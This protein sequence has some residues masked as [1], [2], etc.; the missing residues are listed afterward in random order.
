MLAVGEHLLSEFQA[1]YVC[2]ATPFGGGVGGTHEEL[3]GAF[4]SGLMVIGARR[5][6]AVVQED[7]RA[8]YAL[9]VEYRRWF[10]ERWGTLTCGPIRDWAKGATGPGGCGPVVAEAARILLDLLQDP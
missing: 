5:G 4:T 2:M 1:R 10:A 9:A 6:R 8:A 3:C 7:D